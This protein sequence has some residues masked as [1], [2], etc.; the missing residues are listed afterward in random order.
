MATFVVLLILVNEMD[1]DGQRAGR[2]AILFHLNFEPAL[3]Y[4]KT[5]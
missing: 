5:H 1:H 2:V 4:V 3:C